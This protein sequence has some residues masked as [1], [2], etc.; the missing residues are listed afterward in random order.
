M[1][2]TIPQQYSTKFA[3]FFAEFDQSLEQLNIQSYGISISTLEEV[4][5]KIGHLDDPVINPVTNAVQTSH[6]EDGLAKTSTPF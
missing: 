1:T 5:L 2:I 6:D 3:E 4:F